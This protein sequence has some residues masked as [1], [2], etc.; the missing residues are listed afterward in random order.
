MSNN[1][2]KPEKVIEAVEQ[3]R[4]P[5]IQASEY[6]FLDDLEKIHPAPSKKG[7][8]G[9]ANWI[10]DL[11]VFQVE[12]DGE[13]KTV[14]DEGLIEEADKLL[15]EQHGNPRYGRNRIANIAY[16]SENRPGGKVSLAHN[17][18]DGH[19]RLLSMVNEFY[20][21]TG[22]EEELENLYKDSD[23]LPGCDNMA[24]GNVFGIDPATGLKVA[25]DALD[26]YLSEDEASDYTVIP[27]HE[28][29]SSVSTQNQK[30]NSGG[31]NNM[32]NDYDHSRNTLAGTVA[33]H[34]DASSELVHAAARLERE[35]GT[36]EATLELAEN[37]KEAGIGDHRSMQSYL[38]SQ[39]DT[40]F[41]TFSSV[42]ED[43]YDELVDVARDL[44]DHDAPS[45]SSA[46]ALDDATGYTGR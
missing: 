28:E 33:K 40:D 14:V 22:R 31:D 34:D 32:T 19:E 3:V 46:R 36:A 8:D 38:D 24:G 25:V 2:V 23:L 35:L 45:D 21:E 16:D 6:S 18:V 10:A 9:L 37:Y 26:E 30:S 27:V 29:D 11:A 12:D 17:Q 5:E 44:A 42:L 13:E 15:A 20:R 43:A 7:N 41:E 39:M 1:S 4:D